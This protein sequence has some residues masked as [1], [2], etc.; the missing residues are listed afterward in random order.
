VGLRVI[1]GITEGEI[2]ES[3]QCMR[4]LEK[5]EEIGRRRFIRDRQRLM[6]KD[7]D[8]DGISEL[9]LDD[10]AELESKCL[11]I[12]IFYSQKSYNPQFLFS[13]MLKAWGISNLAVV[14]K[15]GDYCFKLEFMKR[16]KLEL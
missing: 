4:R 12:A 7:D 9:D 2:Q 6:V 8:E 14:E 3:K 1:Q 16:E 10:E 5:K 13:D 15:I 11:T